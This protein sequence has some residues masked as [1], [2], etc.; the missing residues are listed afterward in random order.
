MSDLGVVILA[1]GHG[2]RMKSKKNKVLHEIGGIPMV[3]LVYG[4]AMAVSDLPPVV[5]VGPG[6]EEIESLLGDRAVYVEQPQQMGT[7]H[8]TMMATQVLQGKT[9]QILVT[10]ADMPLLRS[11]TMAQLAQ[12]QEES[13][14]AV[15]ILTV[16][17]DPE[18]TFGRIMRDSNGRVAEIVEVA[19]AK[20][21]DNAQEILLNRELNA[22]VYCFESAWLWTNLPK[23]PLRQARNGQEYYLTDMVGLAVS[24]G[25]A[26][27][28]IVVDDP[29]EC[30]GAGNRQELAVVEKAFRR[31][32]I[33]EW[34]DN[35]VTILD[36]EATYI[37]HAVTIGRDTVIW[38]NT[39]LQ[40]ASDI[41]EECLLGPN[42]VIRNATIGHRCH[43]EQAVVEGIAIDDGT[44]VEPF[45]HLKG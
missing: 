44:V 14:A 32:I 13:K 1:A 12:K 25:L 29:D 24:K 2:T 35:G 28:A 7:G 43:I 42:A 45:S 31:R 26:V 37:G 17:G 5:V 9:E 20:R 4:S 38:P 33:K 34:M 11:S 23:L 30:L 40:G 19:E 21:R 22:G 15:V 6:E 41:G 16:M 18:S 36:P 3:E 8:A 39:Y 10:Y 27:E